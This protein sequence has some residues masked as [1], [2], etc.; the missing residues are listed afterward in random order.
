MFIGDTYCLEIFHLNPETSELYSHDI[1]HISCSGAVDIVVRELL[2]TREAAE[3]HVFDEDTCDKHSWTLH[4]NGTDLQVI[5]I[6][7]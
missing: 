3:I 4:P 6:H 2:T 7:K 5:E 1:I